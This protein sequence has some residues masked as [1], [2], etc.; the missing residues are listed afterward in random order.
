MHDSEHW[1]T[2]CPLKGELIFQVRERDSE[3]PAIGTETCGRDAP[4]TTH[5]RRESFI[6]YASLSAGSLQ[7]QRRY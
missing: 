7:T 2:L 5:R 3:K 1:F 4:A 6:M